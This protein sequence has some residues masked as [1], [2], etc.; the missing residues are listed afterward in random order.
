MT[1][2]VS[3]GDTHGTSSVH[4]ETQG[5][6]ATSGV[7]F[8]PA[9]GA[10]LS[11]RSHDS[12]DIVAYRR[13]LDES[14]EVLVVNLE[15]E[16]WSHPRRTRRRDDHRRRQQPVAPAQS[17]TT[18]E[19]SALP[20]TL[21]ATG[22]DGDPLTYSIVARPATERFRLGSESRPTRRRRASSAPGCRSDS[23]LSRQAFR[24]RA[25]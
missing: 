13:S 4:Y 16:R 10:E 7:D 17:L 2:T 22:P 25:G 11:Y 15:P 12:D 20:V 21:A 18:D 24:G 6:T 14:D 8:T 1:F 19:D 23:H 3:D 5:V 9:S